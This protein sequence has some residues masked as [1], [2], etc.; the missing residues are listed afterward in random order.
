MNRLSQ[1]GGISAG[2]QRGAG[3]TGK[4]VKAAEPIAVQRDG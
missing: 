2:L 4:Q 3:I 1:S